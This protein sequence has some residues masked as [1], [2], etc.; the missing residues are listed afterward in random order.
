VQILVKTDFKQKILS[1][2]TA[3]DYHL[4][5]NLNFGTKY[6][7]VV[8]DIDFYKE[9]FKANYN[10]NQTPHR[11]LVIAKDASIQAE[12]YNQIKPTVV[13]NDDESDLVVNKLIEAA[14]QNRKTSQSLLARENI[15]NKRDELEKLNEFLTYQDKERTTALKIFHAE[16]QA[17]KHHEKQL[18][19]FLDFIN[20]NYANGSFLDELLKYMWN[21]IKKIGSFYQMGIIVKFEGDDQAVLFQYDDRRYYS[22]KN[23]NFEKPQSIDAASFTGFLANL[24]QRPVGKILFWQEANTK[25]QFHFYLETQGKEYKNKDIELFISDRIS[26]LSLI[27]SRWVTEKSEETLLRQW[28]NT[29]KAYKDPIHVVDEEFNIIQANYLSKSDDTRTNSANTVP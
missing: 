17:K 28:R 24:Y 14:A 10:L 4:E 19:F 9:L 13:L 26:L 20:S 23:I 15:E 5:S 21:E 22:Q 29:F 25:V 2:L 27:I 11:I 1:R 18:L 16:E 3:S 6:D 8:G 12:F 7:G